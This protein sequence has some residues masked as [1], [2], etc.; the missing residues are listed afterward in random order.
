MPKREEAL[1]KAK[2]SIADLNEELQDKSVEYK[3]MK[4][5]YIEA[6]RENYVLTHM[7]EN[8]SESQ[9]EILANYAKDELSECVTM[10]EFRKAFN[11]ACKDV[12][13]INETVSTPVKKTVKKAEKKQESISDVL[14][15]LG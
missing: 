1:L 14:F 4:K 15:R 9:K 11:K 2:S 12:L 3:R 5:A 10:T 8:I 7:P 6:K 13:E